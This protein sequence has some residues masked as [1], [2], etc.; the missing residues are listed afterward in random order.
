MICKDMRIILLKWFGTLLCLAG[1]ALTSFNV[2]PANIL[3]SFVG[4]AAWTA[5]GLLQRDPP[6]FIVELVAVILYLGGLVTYML[7]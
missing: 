6:L 2:Y 1:I 5:A 7:S 3:L 4:S